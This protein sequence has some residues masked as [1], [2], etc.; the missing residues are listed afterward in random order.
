MMLEMRL[1]LWRLLAAGFLFCGLAVPGVYGQEPAKDSSLVLHYMFDN[2]PG[3]IAK[4]LSSG[5]NDGKI[6]KAQFVAAV[7][8]RRGAL[9]FDGG[10][11]AISCPE[12]DSLTFGGDMS[13]EMRVK[14]NAP[15][16]R[17]E[18]MIFGDGSIL[19]F[20]GQ[21]NSVSLDYRTRLG[22]M[23]LPLDPKVLSDRW[24][25]LAVVIEY[26]RCRFYHNGELAWDA[27]M[28]APIIGKEPSAGAKA[29]TALD[30]NW[31][32]DNMP[33]PLGRAK[34]GKSSWV[35]GGGCAMDLGEFRLY[36]RALTAEEIAAHAKG[37]ELQPGRAAEL[38]VEPNWY[39]G[40]VAVRVSCQ[41]A[42][43]RGGEAEIALLYGDGRHAAAQRVTLAESAEGSG[44]Q[45]GTAAFELAGLENESVDA[46]AR[47][48]EADGKPVATVC[49]HA[50]LTKPAWVKNSEGLSDTVLPPWTPLE[51]EAGGDGAVELR[52]WG[53]RHVFTGAPFPQK[54]ET[55]GAEILAVPITLTGRADGKSLAWTDGRL[56]LKESTKTAATLD[57]AAENPDA[58]LRVA[59]RMEY[60]G[61]MVFDCTVQARREMRL[62]AL[63]LQIPLQAR[64]AALC[65]GDKVFPDDDKI[66]IAAWYSGAVKGDLAFRFSPCVWLGNEERGLCWQAESDEDWRCADPQ[67]AI[68]ILPRGGTTTFC[69]HLVDSPTTLAAGEKLHYRFALE[70]TPVKPMLRDAWDFRILRVDPFGENQALR[71]PDETLGGKPTLQYFADTGARHMYLNI[72]DVNPYPMPIHAMYSQALHRLLDTAHAYGLRSYSY[73]IHERFPTNVPEFDLYGLD[74]SSL[75]L[76]PYEGTI[77]MCVKS[78]ALQDAYIY[79]LAR[80]L[81]EYGDDGVYLD[82]TVH[83]V[84]CENPL[85]GCGWR[86]KDGSVHKTYP[87]F[88]N[89]E[90]MRRI[91]AVVKQRRPE[92]IV[93]MHCSWGYNIPALAYT[94]L[95]WSGEQ[96]W[97]L[98]GKGT[99]YVAKELTLDKF[100]TEFMGYPIGVPA[101]TLDYR[102]IE[103]HNFEATK[104]VLAT[105]LL[106]DVPVRVRTA[107]KVNF[108][109]T[110]KVWKL[111]DEF[112]AKEAE[113]LFYW[114]NQDYVQVSPEK[115]YATL[116]KHP[117][118]GVLAFITNLRPDAQTVAVQLNLETLGLKG[119]TLNVFNALTGEPVAMTADGKVSVPLGS[120]E[121]A[122]IWFRPNAAR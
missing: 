68:E 38:M 29:T 122:Y 22:G 42:E 18:G 26:P 91:Y 121:W 86:A 37:Q 16:K 53:R 107:A 13:F 15:E 35:I 21:T 81:D 67:K 104:K 87:V 19:Q 32:M 69:A 39:A 89:R 94:D 59:T 55:G 93:D 40:R 97:H 70:A 109:L 118:N 52:V 30:P 28:P 25:H 66:P 100:K 7:E 85:H 84:P 20:Y 63:T 106:H 96:W 56:I 31:L 74:M 115:C 111:R 120:E 33:M 78:R 101:E 50:C 54:I 80:R 9:R 3:G 36:R 58:S 49:R 48:F 108:E 102:L 1:H 5:G 77:N 17:G 113:R 79:S 64:Y 103:W 116:F 47:I 72:E 62:E 98:R 99:N 6:V 12:S 43:C 119:R 76:E 83:I 105:S 46:V 75:P 60:D 51:A 45:V 95:L 4:D 88:A 61:Y 11:S 34:A 27:F 110:P 24:S 114:K 14:L 10:Q 71:L 112:G 8:G 23:R 117:K 65:Y 82:G 44:R 90:F 73:L 2:D 57:H 41:G 92:G